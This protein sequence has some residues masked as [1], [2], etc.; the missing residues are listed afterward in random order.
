[1]VRTKKLHPNP[2]SKPITK[3]GLSMRCWL[4][5]DI[6]RCNALSKGWFGLVPGAQIWDCEWFGK[7]SRVWIGMV[8]GLE[9]CPD[10]QY[11]L[12]NVLLE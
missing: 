12:W 11:G 9:R 10:V 3:P 6:V 1:M 2:A 8:D 4:W 7:V 5:Y